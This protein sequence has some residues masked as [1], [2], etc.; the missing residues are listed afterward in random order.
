[1]EGSDATWMAY[2]CPHRRSS[3][4]AGC[5]L[6]ARA[7]HD[8]LTPESL[9]R[10]LQGVVTAPPRAGTSPQQAQRSGRRN[11]RGRGRRWRC[12][13]HF[14]GSLCRSETRRSGGS[15]FQCVK[16]HREV[17]RAIG[18]RS[19]PPCPSRPN[20]SAPHCRQAMTSGARTS[21]HSD[22]NVRDIRGVIGVRKLP[23]DEVQVF[24]R[25]L[26]SRIRASHSH[27]AR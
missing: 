11:R 12:G 3:S 21:R 18:S 22:H 2:G 10:R 24:R 17:K 25:V 4:A 23:G 8:D 15:I 27:T 6:P 7:Q 20:S 26:R 5:A 9:R 13:A 16:E 19:R 1:M 14:S